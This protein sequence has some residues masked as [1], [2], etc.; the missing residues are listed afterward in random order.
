[1]CLLWKLRNSKLLIPLFYLCMQ[2]RQLQTGMKDKPSEATE[3]LKR[4]FSTRS[5]WGSALC[6]AQKRDKV[7]TL[8]VATWDWMQTV[9]KWIL[10]KI[11]LVSTEKMVNQS[12]AL[13]MGGIL[14]FS[15][16]GPGMAPWLRGS[17]KGLSLRRYHLSQM[18]KTRQPCHGHNRI[19]DKQQCVQRHW[20]GREE[21][22]SD[23]IFLFNC[24]LDMGLKYR[25]KKPKS[26]T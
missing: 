21:K 14:C 26:F 18:T 23:I 24:N 25:K 17:R 22:A 20:G 10:L 13:V 7:Q 8:I 16:D 9:N 4:S 2:G 12:N 6:C 1:M 19:P 5:S 3:Y 11:V 15:A